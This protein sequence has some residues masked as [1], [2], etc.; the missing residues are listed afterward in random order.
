[1]VTMQKI[2]EHLEAYENKTG[3]L[4]FIKRDNPDYQAILALG[5]EAVPTLL[6]SIDDFGWEVLALLGEITQASPVPEEHYGKY[7]EVV[8]AWKNW[9]IENGYL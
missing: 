7:H 4:S 6:C 3:G 8:K 1:M 9:G 2:I 5:L